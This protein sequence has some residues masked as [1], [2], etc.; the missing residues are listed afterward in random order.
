ML[1]IARMD[2]KSMCLL[3]STIDTHDHPYIQGIP[4]CL[5][6]GSC[7]LALAEVLDWAEVEGWSGAEI[8]N[9]KATWLS[10][11]KLTTFG[12]DKG[13]FIHCF[14]VEPGLFSLC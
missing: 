10:G 6:H 12:F 11:V 3:L 14:I 9:L 8:N 1:L 13:K 4:M 5:S 7:R 2:I